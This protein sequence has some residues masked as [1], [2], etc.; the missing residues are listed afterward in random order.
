VSGVDEEAVLE[1]IDGLRPNSEG[2]V[3][4]I[5]PF[6]SEK[7]AA[8][9]RLSFNH[10]WGWYR[11]WNP[12]CSLSRDKGFK[13]RNWVVSNVEREVVERPKL[14]LPDEFVPLTDSIDIAVPFYGRRYYEYLLRR[15]V[16]DQAIIDL[17]IGYCN[18]GPYG[19]MVIIPVRSDGQLEGYAGRAVYAKIFKNASNEAGGKRAMLNGDALRLDTDQPIYIVEGPFDA[20]RHYPY[21]AACLGKPTYEQI[22]VLRG[23]TRPVY[24]VLDADAW[25]ESHALACGLRMWAG[26][27]ATP[28]FLPPGCDPGAT[29]PSDLAAIA[30]ETFE[31]IDAGSIRLPE[32]KEKEAPDSNLFV[33]GV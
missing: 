25:A 16:P 15:G 30:S 21:A 31:R 23:V 20:L 8:K 5:C 2:W 4:A 18:Y 10:D 13:V 7:R 32:I 14:V 17:E 6:C 9:R 1:A 12:G 22:A 28:I 3:Y 11:C 29:S 24:I 33:N 19:G 26:I 27:D